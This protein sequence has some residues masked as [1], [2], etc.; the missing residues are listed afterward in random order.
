MR[1]KNCCITA[2]WRISSL[3]DLT[4]RQHPQYTCQSSNHCFWTW[5]Q[6][7]TGVT[8]CRQIDWREKITAGIGIGMGIGIYLP[9]LECPILRERGTMLTQTT[10]DKEYQLAVAVAGAVKALDEL[11]LVD[12]PH[13]ADA[14]PKVGEMGQVVIA[15]GGVHLH[16]GAHHW[17]KAQVTRAPP[18][19]AWKCHW[20]PLQPMHSLNYKGPGTMLRHSSWEQSSG[21]ILES[22]KRFA[23]QH[24]YK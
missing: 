7:I 2:S 6:V 17:H 5:K 16:R 19:A 4:C 12:A 13:K 1:A 18:Q 11:G 14:V 23:R 8:V 21:P 3:P 22:K 20:C 24:I 10:G 15:A 9:P